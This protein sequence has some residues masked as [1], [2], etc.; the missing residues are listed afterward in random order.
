M[1]LQ[2]LPVRAALLRKLCTLAT[3]LA[4]H[5]NPQAATSVCWALAT[6]GLRDLK[7]LW[8]LAQ[9]VMA[10]EGGGH[11]RPSID[12]VVRYPADVFGIEAI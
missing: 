12:P 4:M 7:L 1:L 2:A 9:R 10:A 5:M 11:S 6:L 8:A 3:P